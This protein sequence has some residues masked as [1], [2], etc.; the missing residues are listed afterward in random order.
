MDLALYG[1]FFGHG[2]IFKRSQRNA[3]KD[4]QSVDSGGN[5]KA[6]IDPMMDLTLNRVFSPHLDPEKCWYMLNSSLCGL[7]CVLVSLKPSA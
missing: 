4:I 7:I 5:G 2:P 1:K 6:V 3:S